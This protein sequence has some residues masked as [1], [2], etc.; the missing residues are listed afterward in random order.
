MCSLL[1]RKWECVTVGDGMEALT[2]L[3]NNPGYFDVILSDIMVSYL[4]SA[5]LFLPLSFLS[6]LLSISNSGTAKND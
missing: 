3:Q 6:S 4:G 2:M 5:P 1:E